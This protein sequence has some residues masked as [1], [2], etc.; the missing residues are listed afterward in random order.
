MSARSKMCEKKGSFYSRAR[1]EKSAA[2]WGQRVYECPI[3]FCWHCTSKD[4]WQEEFVDAE[5]ARKQLVQLESTLRNEFNKKLK[6]KNLRIMELERS[7]S[8]SN[9]EKP[10]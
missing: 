9:V 5:K 6:E 10:E 8:K 2:K 1:A 4:N 3:C 7:L